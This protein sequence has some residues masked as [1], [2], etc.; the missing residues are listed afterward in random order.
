MSELKAV[1]RIV[2]AFAEEAVPALIRD[3]NVP[4]VNTRT[5]AQAAIR[6]VVTQDPNMESKRVWA[7]VLGIVGLV[8]GGIA[9]ALMVPEAKE[10]FGPAAPMW[11]AIF[12]SIA[13]GLGGGAA[14]VSKALDPR[15]T[16]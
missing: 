5:E 8:L 7:G 12:G 6:R 13:S 15:P 9:A 10:V 1:G 11:A 2:A 4:S 16:R 14:L 3:D